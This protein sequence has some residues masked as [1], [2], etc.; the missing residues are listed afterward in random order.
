MTTD[1]EINWP[2]QAAIDLIALPSRDV[3]TKRPSVK[4]GE[5][6]FSAPR[7]MFKAPMPAK[8]GMFAIHIRTRHWM[9][10]QFEP[11]HFGESSNL[12]RKLAVDGGG[13]FV[14]WLMHPEAI[15]GL[16]V[17]LC[18]TTAMNKPAREFAVNRLLARYR[19][20]LLRSADDLMAELNDP[21]AGNWQEDMSAVAAHKE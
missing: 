7:M 13:E 10:W 12:Y 19:P 5:W 21:L 15:N 3:S 9:K 17:S 1:S 2:R 8:S 16:F 11:I 14:R 4:Y 6:E 20:D 18:L